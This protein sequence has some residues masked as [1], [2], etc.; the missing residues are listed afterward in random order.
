LIQNIAANP[1]F[2]YGIVFAHTSC[3]L[4][5]ASG[6][7]GHRCSRSTFA[8]GRAL[9]IVA[10][11]SEGDGI[12]QAGNGDPVAPSVI[13]LVWQRT[14]VVAARRE[15]PRTSQEQSVFAS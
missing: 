15:Q 3:T 2:L 5:A 6:R 11:L 8:L 1:D 14:I 9:P 13:P 4:F 12:G 7:I 10:A